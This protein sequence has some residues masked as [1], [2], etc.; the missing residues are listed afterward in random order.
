MRILG[1]DPGFEKMGCAVLDKSNS[2]EKL[3]Y[4]VCLVSDRKLPYEQR[5]L[6]LGKELEK[7]ISKYNPDIMIIEKLFFTKNQKT[8]IRVAESRGVAIYLASVKKI[9]VTELTPLQIKSAVT[10]Y[11]KAEKKQVE[12]M[13]KVILKIPIMPKSDDEI[14][15]IAAAIA[16]PLK[17]NYKDIHSEF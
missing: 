8:G 13:I 14:D 16:C 9:P 4:S 5:L 6:F 3:V 1:I 12:K 7:I 17:L 15:A 2:K 11:G 10:G